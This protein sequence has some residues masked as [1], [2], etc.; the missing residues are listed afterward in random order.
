MEAIASREK[1]FSCL[2]VF[3][4]NFSGKFLNR[5]R[6]RAIEKRYT[7]VTKNICLEKMISI[8]TGLK[9]LRTSD[10]LEGFTITFV[11]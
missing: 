7:K 8:I 3:G 10:K 6:V 11:V 2:F 1:S 4:V 9:P 5:K